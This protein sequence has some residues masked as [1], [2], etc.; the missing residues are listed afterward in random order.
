MWLLT[1]E[2][3]SR[4]MI[5]RADQEKS[6]QNAQGDLHPDGSYETSAEPALLERVGRRTDHQMPSWPVQ[7]FL[8]KR[9]NGP[10]KFS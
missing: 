9:R 3:V 4:P 6:R 8:Q 10:V 5:I 2:V 1:L 7:G